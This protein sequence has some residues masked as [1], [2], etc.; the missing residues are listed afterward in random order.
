MEIHIAEPSPFEVEIGIAH[1]KKYKSPG[2][3][4]IVAELIQA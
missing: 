2:T 3:N 4:Q 1:L